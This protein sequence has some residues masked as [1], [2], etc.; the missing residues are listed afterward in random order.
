MAFTIKRFNDLLLRTEYLYRVRPTRWTEDK[1]LCLKM[2]KTIVE[3][4]S[5]WLNCLGQPH[6]IIEVEGNH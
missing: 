4:E 2:D 6:E 5:K 1:F 3:K